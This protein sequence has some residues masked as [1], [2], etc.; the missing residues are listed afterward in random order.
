MSVILCP[1]PPAQVCPKDAVLAVGFGIVLV[2]RNGK[3]VWGGDDEHVRLRRFERRAAR[4]AGHAKGKW[5]V[6]FIGALADTLY[7]RQRDGRWHLTKR[8]LGCA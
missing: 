5:T 7:T 2:R 6:H 1:P 3:V 8:G 4:E